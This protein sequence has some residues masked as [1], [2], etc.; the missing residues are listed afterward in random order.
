VT[1]K[2]QGE[3]Q[4]GGTVQ[5]E[6]KPKLRSNPSTIIREW[7]PVAIIFQKRADKNFGWNINRYGASPRKPFEVNKGRMR[8]ISKK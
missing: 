2:P 3:I 1:R 5:R 7:K 8:R 4:Q 6:H